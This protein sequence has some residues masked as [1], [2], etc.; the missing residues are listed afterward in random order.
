[1]LALTPRGPRVGLGGCR[2]EGFAGCGARPNE[3]LAGA[4]LTVRSSG[5]PASFRISNGRGRRPLS[6]SVR[7]AWEAV[8]G[9]QG[10]LA[11]GT[12]LACCLLLSRQAVHAALIVG[13]GGVLGFGV[14]FNAAWSAGRSWRLQGGGLRGLWC[15][16]KQG[17]AGAHL[18]VR[19]SG[20][21]ASFRVCSGRGRRPLSSGVRRCK[22]WR[23]L[24]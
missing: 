1:M 12:V 10:F 22:T 7:W 6:S 8:S 13:F 18:T 16:A 15:P 21:P 2:V 3:G 23:F 14:G 4:H 17:L 11:S 5:P 19:S 9:L 20:P 24:A